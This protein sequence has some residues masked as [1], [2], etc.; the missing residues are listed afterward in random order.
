MTLCGTPDVTGMHWLIPPLTRTCSFQEGDPVEE[1]VCQFASDPFTM[2]VVDD[3]ANV[4]LVKFICVVKID[5]DKIVTGF[6]DYLS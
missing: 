2:E 6:E 4:Y 3:N 1:L 5:Y